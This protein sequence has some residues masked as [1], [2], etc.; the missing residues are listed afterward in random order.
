MQIKSIVKAN[1]IEESVIEESV[2]EER[3]EK[4]GF[5]GCS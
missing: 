2:I 3:I 1:V 4:R 5:S